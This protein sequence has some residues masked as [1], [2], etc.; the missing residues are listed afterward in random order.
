MICL[1]VSPPADAF[2]LEPRNDKNRGR[3]I[4][5]A[6]DH[7]ALRTRYNESDLLRRLLLPP[8]VPAAVILAAAVPVVSSVVVPVAASASAAA[9]AT[10]TRT[11]A[12]SSM[13]AVDEFFYSLSSLKQNIL[14]G[15]FSTSNC[16][17]HT[18]YITSTPI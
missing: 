12:V 18:R 17:L 14:Q 4:T 13:D 2:L 10:L 11:V 7:A 16:V 3:F 6:D 1:I 8:V 9:A 5:S 15:T